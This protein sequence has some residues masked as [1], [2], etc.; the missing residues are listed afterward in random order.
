MTNPLIVV[1][2]QLLDSVAVVFVAA[3]AVFDAADVFA[4]VLDAEGVVDSVSAAG[5]VDV[6]VVDVR[7]AEWA[8]KKFPSSSDLNHLF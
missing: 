7:A 6:A 8:G 2:R 3:A 1:Q 5:V 4:N